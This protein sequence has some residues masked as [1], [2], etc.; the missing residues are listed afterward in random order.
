[1]FFSTSESIFTILSYHKKF[2]KRQNLNKKIKINFICEQNRFLQFYH[3]TKNFQNEKKIKLWG[4]IF[5]SFC[6]Y[7][8]IIFDK[9]Q[10]INNFSLHVIIKFDA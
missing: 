7:N 3:I 9:S 2:D 4:F 10:K 1:M 5:F 6:F 8:F